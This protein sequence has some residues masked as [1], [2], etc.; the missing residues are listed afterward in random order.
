MSY[1]K[2]RRSM[3]EI[4]FREKKINSMP[5]HGYMEVMR[6]ALHAVNHVIPINHVPGKWE[7][8]LHESLIF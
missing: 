5:S 1:P 4:V 7:I 6:K 3:L 8:Y 2:L